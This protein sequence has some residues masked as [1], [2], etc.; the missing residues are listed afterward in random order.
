[1]RPGENPLATDPDTIEPN[2]LPTIIDAP[3]DY[4][5]R[6]GNRVTVHHIAPPC[7]GVTQF[8]AKGSIWR[9]PTAMGQNPPYS[10]WHISGRYYALGEHPLDIVKKVQPTAESGNE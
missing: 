8:A 9:K 1:M 3:G 5:A 10:I 4:V 7:K 6:N 2:C